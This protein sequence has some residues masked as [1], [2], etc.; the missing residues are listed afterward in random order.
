MSVVG[1]PSACFL[2]AASH[3]FNYVTGLTSLVVPVRG[4]YPEGA[5]RSGP[6][7][8]CP[9][10]GVIFFGTLLEALFGFGVYPDL[11]AHQRF[12]LSGVE[13]TDDEVRVVGRIIEFVEE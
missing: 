5:P 11:E 4:E 8:V 12:V 13:V 3:T 9:E 2:P 1:T 10:S 7:D 6:F